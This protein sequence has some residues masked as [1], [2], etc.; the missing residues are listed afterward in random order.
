MV[1]PRVSRPLPGWL[2]TPQPPTP[3]TGDDDMPEAAAVIRDIGQ[4]KHEEGV[5]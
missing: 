1:I 3:D 4:A 5:Q 2:S